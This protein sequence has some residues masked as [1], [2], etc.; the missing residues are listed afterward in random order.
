[1]NK[2]EALELIKKALEATSEGSSAEVTMDTHLTED[3]VLDSL[4][5][6]NM[7]FELEQL[8]GKKLEAIDETFEDFRVATL[9]DILTNA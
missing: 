7:L 4:D 9:V 6:M 8:F 3:D 1:M 5:A 2:D